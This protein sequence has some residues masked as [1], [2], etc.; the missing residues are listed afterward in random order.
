MTGRR[1]AGLA[2]A[3]LALTVL[4]GC[5]PALRLF[6]ARER[7]GE[8]R[9]G[10]RFV[11][12]VPSSVDAAYAWEYQRH[13]DD[14][15]VL[16]ETWYEP[17]EPGQGLWYFS[18]TALRAGEMRL[19]YICRRVTDPTASPQANYYFYLTVQP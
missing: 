10:Q 15:V 7:S 4:V 2:A 6:T 19:H 17:G 18:Y 13:P 14:G 9:V 12:T 1:R 5:A 8:V 11:V 3:L 16:R